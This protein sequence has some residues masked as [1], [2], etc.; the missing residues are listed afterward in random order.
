MSSSN[1]PR[2]SWE[3][4]RALFN[5]LGKGPSEAGLTLVVLRLVMEVEAL[6]EA[7]SRPETPEAVRQSYRKAYERIAVLSHNGAGPS[8]GMEKI[9][10]RFF[11][12]HRSSEESIPE[13]AM[14]ER[15]GATEEER[16]AVLEQMEL[17]ETYT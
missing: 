8:D 14:L 17:A 10:E 6:R 9:L 7:L 13:L 16:K 1:F 12:E 11:P 2:S 5:H 15:L 4:Y 3:I